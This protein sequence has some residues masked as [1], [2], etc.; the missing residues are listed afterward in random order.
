MR[1][2]VSS[3]RAGGAAQ[4]SG[5]LLLR[6][7]RACAG[8]PT[9]LRRCTSRFARLLLAPARLA[10]RFRDFG[11]IALAA[12][13]ARLELRAG[14]RVAREQLAVLRDDAREPFLPGA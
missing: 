6:G 4:F 8:S 3:R 9:R 14:A 2:S 7:R 12:L 13:A 5:G 10:A 1:R 11:E